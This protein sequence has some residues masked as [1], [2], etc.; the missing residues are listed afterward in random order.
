M[1]SYILETARDVYESRPD[2]GFDEVAA[3]AGIKVGIIR[4]HF[5]T[6]ADLRAQATA[7]QIPPVQTRV[8]A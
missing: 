3:V 1:L 8:R 5:A 2:A 4:S 6:E 7:A